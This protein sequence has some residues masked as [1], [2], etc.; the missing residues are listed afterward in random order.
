MELQGPFPEMQ[1]SLEAWSAGLKEKDSSSVMDFII[2]ALISKDPI[3]L[4]VNESV[5]SA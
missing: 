5:Y 1:N 4:P 3:K 2:D